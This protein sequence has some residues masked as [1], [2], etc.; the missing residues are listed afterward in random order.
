MGQADVFKAFGDLRNP[1][2]LHHDVTVGAFIQPATGVVGVFTFGHARANFAAVEVIHHEV[3]THAQ[4]HFVHRNI[5][6]F[7]FAGFPHLIQ[8][9][10]R[11]G[12]G[13]HAGKVVGGVREGGHRLVD[14]AV[15]DQIAAEGLSDGVIGRKVGVLLGTV[16]A[17]A[18]QVSDNQFRVMLPQ[19]VIGDSTAGK[20]RTFTGFNE[21]IG[22]FHQFQKRFPPF[23]FKNIQRE[24]V[25]ITPRQ[26]RIVRLNADGIGPGDVLNPDHFCA[27]FGKHLPGEWPGDFDPGENNPQPG[28]RPKSRHG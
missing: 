9:R 12:G 15:L 19:D 13:R 7:A 26:L 22:G 6:A 5:D 16:L 8:C 2:Q 27:P 21:D 10:Q 23:I 4:H 17:E 24:R 20:R 25:Q 3:L 28:K 18:G 1:D 14:V 11:G